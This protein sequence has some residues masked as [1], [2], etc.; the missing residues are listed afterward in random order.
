MSHRPNEKIIVF[1]SKCSIIENCLSVF[2]LT[3]LQIAAA[4]Y[5]PDLRPWMRVTVIR[6]PELPSA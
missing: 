4:P 2:L 1:S 5:S 3:P 6:D